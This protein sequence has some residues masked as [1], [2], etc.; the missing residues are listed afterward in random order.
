MVFTNFSYCVVYRVGGVSIDATILL[1]QDGMFSIVESVHKYN[2]G[3]DL[4]TKKLSEFLASE[5]K[6]FEKISNCRKLS[7]TKFKS[8]K[9]VIAHFFFRQYRTAEI[10]ER[11][12]Y[13]L[14]AAA[15][16]VKQ[17]LSI[18]NVAQCSCESIGSG[19]DFSISVSRARFEN[20]IA[21]LIPEIVAPI[22]EVLD[23]ASLHPYKIKKVN[24]FIQKWQVLICVI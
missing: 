22:T 2:L 5:F 18:Q 9:S 17:I 3:G 12:K 8:L 16:S 20:I 1:V 7:V 23:K 19:Y 4:F 21:S 15:E 13:K 11:G 6:R 24:L 10:S 14:L